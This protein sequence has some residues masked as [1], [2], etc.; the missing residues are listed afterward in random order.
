MCYRP[1]VIKNPK[2]GKHMSVNC[3]QCLECRQKRSRE[4]SLR[5]MFEASKFEHNSFLTLTYE[6]S[7]L[8][9][10]KRDLQLFFKRLR[11]RL[12]PLKIRYF[13]CGEYGDKKKR[14]H[15]HIILFNYDFP[16]KY[17]I[18]DSNTGHSQYMS[19]FLTDVW[20]LGRCTIEDVTVNSCAYCA[21]YSSLGS[22]ALPK[23][24]QGYPEFNVMSRNIGVDVMLERFDEYIKTDEIYFDG[25]KYNIPQC[26]LNKVYSDRDKEFNLTYLS[27]KKAR[28]DKARL[29]GRLYL[30]TAREDAEYRSLR[31]F[32]KINKIL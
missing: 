22:K 4:W 31:K 28:V 27:L 23:F 14:P 17:R 1:V 11:K 3:R 15:F 10:K 18:E 9:L 2:T 21:L 6:K 20:S 32:Q 25:K 16:D 5:C 8:F 12:D 30:G 29:S 26:V 24:L 13:A 19:D 7:P